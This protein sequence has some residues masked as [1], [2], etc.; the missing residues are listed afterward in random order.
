MGK[1]KRNKEININIDITRPILRGSAGSVTKRNLTVCV[2]QSIIDYLYSKNAF[3]FSKDELD[4]LCN[5]ICSSFLESTDEELYKNI[6]YILNFDDEEFRGEFLFII[7]KLYDNK[8][9]TL[10][11]FNL[12]DK[13]TVGS[14][15]YKPIIT[16]KILSNSEICRRLKDYS[17]HMINESNKILNVLNETTM[18]GLT[19]S[20][21]DNLRLGSV[22]NELNMN[23]ETP[24]TGEG[25][26]LD[27]DELYIE[28][29]K[30]S[31]QQT[32]EMTDL[33]CIEFKEMY[34]SKSDVC[35]EVLENQNNLYDE[36]LDGVIVKFDD[37]GF[38]KMANDIIL[39]NKDEV[40]LSELI[41]RE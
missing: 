23:F 30:I 1:K 12:Q 6:Q 9:Y 11:L 8:K 7:G 22:L 41:I 5:D 3:V 2:N 20:L 15:I 40:A 19:P 24:L 25:S 17:E 10:D 32:S 13:F 26:I 37:E 31:S 28:L 39:D 4:T 14:D 35:A 38:N 21:Y 33:D 27:L 36:I 16:H 29:D 34:S 18:S